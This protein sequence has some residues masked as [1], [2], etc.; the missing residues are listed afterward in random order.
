MV[1]ACGKPTFCNSSTALA[2][3]ATA[4]TLRRA[5]VSPRCNSCSVTV[6]PVPAA[7]RD[8][9]RQITGSEYRQNRRLLF[10]P[11]TV[12]WH[13]FTAAAEALILAD[14]PVDAVTICRSRCET[15]LSGYFAAAVSIAPLAIS[16]SSSFF[17][18]RQF[19]S[20]RGHA[21]ALRS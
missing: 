7:P 10:R 5:P 9:E 3:G 8:V 15:L 21:A 20:A 19:H 18:F 12:G 17:T 14:S 16:A 4:T 11:Q 6:F 13:E 2:V 1:I